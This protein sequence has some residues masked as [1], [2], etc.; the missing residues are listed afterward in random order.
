[1]GTGYIHK[2]DK[3]GYS[4]KTSGPWE[5][6][7]DNEGRRKHY[8]HPVAISD[9]A[10]AKGIYGL[11]GILFCRDCNK[12]SDLIIVEFKEASPDALSVWS[13][14]CEPKDDYKKH[15]AI[16]CPECGCSNLIL[17]TKENTKTICPKCKEGKLAGMMEWIS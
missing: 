13:G 17:G 11:S 7:R 1:M 6:Y 12:T 2:C 15:E 16:K 8:G 14:K 4:V 3:C 5:F 10:R 9:E